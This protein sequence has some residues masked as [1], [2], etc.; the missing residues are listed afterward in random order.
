[1]RDQKGRKQAY[2]TST[3]VLDVANFGH[4]ATTRPYSPL[5]M[6]VIFMSP[7]SR[8]CPTKSTPELNWKEFEE[9]NVLLRI[10]NC[11]QTTMKSLG[12]KSSKNSP[13]QKV[14]QRRTEMYG[15]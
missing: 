5:A 12:T 7:S 4:F 11:K 9:E 13:V 1:M 3:G 10:R 6:A 2:D 14:S 8:C 15:F